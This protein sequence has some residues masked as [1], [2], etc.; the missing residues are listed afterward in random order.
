VHFTRLEARSPESAFYAFGSKKFRKCM[1]FL[2]KQRVQKVHILPLKA[3]SPEGAFGSKKF[4]K[5]ILCLWKQR[6][7][8]VHILHLEA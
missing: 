7:Q 6:V 4:R 1:F 2:W 8:K 3:R 5:C